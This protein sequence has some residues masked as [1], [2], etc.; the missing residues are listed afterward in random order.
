MTDRSRTWRRAAL[1]VGAGVFSAFAA[2]LTSAVPTD[3][4]VFETNAC[5]SGTYINILAP[6]T[7]FKRG[8]PGFVA[9][10][11][12]YACTS[13]FRRVPCAP[14]RYSAITG[15]TTCESCMPG[16]YCPF[17]EPVPGLTAGVGATQPMP[18]DS[19]THFCPAE[20]P[21]P[22]LVATGYHSVAQPSGTFVAQA[23]CQPGKYCRDG[24]QFD[25]PAG[26]YGAAPGLATPACSGPCAPGHYCKSSSISPTQHE[27]G[28]AEW[29]CPEGSASPS[30]VKDAPIRSYTATYSVAADKNTLD[31]SADV[32]AGALECPRGWYCQHGVARRCP[33]GR[34]GGLTGESS[35]QCAGQC[36]AGYYCPAG[37]AHAQAR[38]CGAGLDIPQSVFCGPGSPAPTTAPPGMYTFGGTKMSRTDVAAC[39]PGSF[40]EHGLQAPCPAGRW[41]AQAGSS[42]PACE[43]AC[44]AGYFCPRGSNL[45]AAEPCG[46]SSVYCPPGS[47][48]PLPAPPGWYTLA[49]REDAAAPDHALRWLA[50][51]SMPTSQGHPDTTQPVWEMRGV[52]G[53]DASALLP[54]DMLS[55]AANAS[56]GEQLGQVAVPLEPGQVAAFL[57]GKGARARLAARLRLQLA[58]LAAPHGAAVLEAAD[59]SASTFLHHVESAVQLGAPVGVVL[60]RRLGELSPNL[61]MADASADTSST[62]SAVALCPRGHY[63][64]VGLLVQCPAGTYGAERGLSSANCSGLCHPGYFCPPGTPSATEHACGTAAMYCPIGSAAPLVVQPGYYS[65]GSTPDTAHEQRICPAG[66][67]CSQGLK[68]ACPGGTFG[69]TDGLA[70]DACSGP[71]EAGWFC[72]PASIRARQLPC[73]GPDVFCPAGSAAPV[74]VSPG[75][76]TVGG[77]T[78]RDGGVVAA[79]QPMACAW[80]YGAAGTVP[81]HTSGDAV[82]HSTY[83]GVLQAWDA[84]RFC[85]GAALGDAVRRTAQAACEPGSFCRGGLRYECPPG[86]YGT[87][88]ASDRPLCD[89]ECAAGYFCSWGSFN[90]SQAACGGPDRYCP[91]GSG[92]PTAARLGYFTNENSGNTTRSAEEPCLPGHYCQA[93]LRYPCAPGRYAA[94]PGTYS[95][96]CEGPCAPG[97]Y[98]PTPGSASATHTAC[99]AGLAV[100]ASVYCPGYTVLPVVV[101]PGGYSIGGIEH[102]PG[103]AENGTRYGVELCEPGHFCQAGEKRQCPGGT[104]GA[105][106]GLAT[107]VCSGPC[108][109]GHFCPPGSASATQFACGEVYMPTGSVTPQQAASLLLD[110]NTAFGGANGAG[111]N[112]LVPLRVT[113]MQVRYS[114]VL[115]WL[116]WLNGTAPSPLPEPV[117]DA[118]GHNLTATA[119]SA[120]L[121]ALADQLR[122]L[123]GPTLANATIGWTAGQQVRLPRFDLQLGQPALQ[124]SLLSSGPVTVYCPQGSAWPASVDSGFYSAGGSPDNM[125][126]S[127]QLA[128]EQGWYC[129]AGVKQPCAAGLVGSSTRGT[130][131]FCDGPCP[132]GHYCPEGSF[133]PTECPDGTYAEAG[134]GSCAA[135]PPDPLPVA[136][137]HEH[138]Y[139]FEHPQDATSSLFLQT[140]CKYARFCCSL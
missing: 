31:D 64:H 97:Y 104:Y 99:G 3:A 27:C 46:N 108:S 70:T 59:G 82:L 116:A 71:C 20:A 6:A 47:G 60:S 130:S 123:D 65:V 10:E 126:R 38:A 118:Q 105:T 93:G 49:L 30:H 15:S 132:A 80:R 92:A 45:A 67:Y 85:T 23:A 63:C 68:L 66:Y 56:A 51:A 2:Q 74:Q 98:C 42:S 50:T 12:G 128:C 35:S 81:S 1:C 28:G 94:L 9:C 73:L 138:T 41:A 14:G 33:A 87:A 124:G 78:A 121:T 39:P 76:Y 8:C 86:R 107:A 48:H 25:C 135:C 69:E 100:P 112:G 5:F 125:T 11:P 139:G 83:V 122:A 79:S 120:E 17:M 117:T 58:R 26:R 13:D 106:Y 113:A 4:E 96:S 137:I 131:R 110:G 119:A 29:W 40:C 18:C 133:E 43:S 72:P 55:V 136:P 19:P 84:S 54:A 103:L 16:F 88:W 102:V 44:R 115:D 53:A 140:K 89:G 34:F 101:P 36:D 52:A 77:I 111:L 57:Q 61:W 129:L 24:V 90:A 62:R 32:R 134:S 37:S 75:Y 109:P 7:L 95:S 91:P 127:H 21:A 22:T 114:A